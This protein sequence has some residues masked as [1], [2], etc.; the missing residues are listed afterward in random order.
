MIFV[1]A[2]VA[3]VP[4]DECACVGTVDCRVDDGAVRDGASGVVADERAD[5][6]V[7]A[8]V[9]FIELDVFNRAAA[10]EDA[11]QALI[12]GATIVNCQVADDVPAAV[13]RAV[14]RSVSRVADWCPVV[15]AAQI[16]VRREFESLAF[17]NGSALIVGGIGVSCEGLQVFN[18]VYGVN[19]IAVVKRVF[20]GIELADAAESFAVGNVKNEVAR[21]VADSYV[22]AREVIGVERDDVAVDY[23]A[24]EVLHAA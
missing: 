11:E 19:D 22:S 3:C 20:E 21:E 4:A 18:G 10:V 12:V 24:V 7:A 6:I 2:D 1:A 5:I 8:D 15:D 16:D 17:R 14:K 9:D 13:E 23:G